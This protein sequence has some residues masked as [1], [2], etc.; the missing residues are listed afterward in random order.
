MKVHNS[1]PKHP[2]NVIPIKTSTKSLVVIA[3]LKD[4]THMLAPSILYSRTLDSLRFSQTAPT[5]P[6]SQRSSQQY[7]IVNN[8]FYQKWI[9]L[10]LTKTC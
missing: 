10:P 4:M 8:P 6:I 1:I 3:P 5:F 9:Y 7:G 2:A